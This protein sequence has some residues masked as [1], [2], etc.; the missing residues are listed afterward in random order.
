MSEKVAVDVL[1]EIHFDAK[2]ED[3]QSTTIYTNARLD[4]GALEEIIT[5]WIQDQMGR[6]ADPEKAVERDLYKIKLGLVLDGDYF[7][8]ESDTGNK[9]L[10]CGIV[11]AVLKDLEKIPKKALSERPA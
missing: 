7:C 5:T 1:V 2:N 3:P 6:G 8:T 4:N 11:M 9:G 10:T